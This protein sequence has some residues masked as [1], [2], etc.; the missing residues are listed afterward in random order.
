MGKPG[1]NGAQDQRQRG[2]FK[3]QGCAARQPDVPPSQCPG[4]NRGKHADDDQDRDRRILEPRSLC[5]RKRCADGA[6]NDCGGGEDIT[7]QECPTGDDSG[8]RTEPVAGIDIERPRARDSGRKHVDLKTYDQQSDCRKTISEPG[9]V[10]GS[11]EDNGDNKPGRAGWRNHTDRL[12]D[13]LDKTQM[14]RF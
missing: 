7:D 8:E 13:D 14:V 2:E 3:Y 5:N 12:G 4:N 10:S 11:R 9:T 6:I 1:D